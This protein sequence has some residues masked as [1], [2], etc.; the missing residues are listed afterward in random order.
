M[1]NSLFSWNWRSAVGQEERSHKLESIQDTKDRPLKPER[2]NPKPLRA[3]LNQSGVMD[4]LSISSP[5]ALWQL[6]SQRKVRSL[7]CC[8]TWSKLPCRNSICASPW[9]ETALRCEAGW[10][11]K[12]AG[13]FSWILSKTSIWIC[14]EGT[15]N[16]SLAYK[17][18]IHLILERRCLWVQ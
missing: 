13:S 2:K 8:G 1:R 4:T 5:P 7:N 9:E 6:H 3:S 16:F 10:G 18:L 11:F 15:S 14:P 17:S 12:Q